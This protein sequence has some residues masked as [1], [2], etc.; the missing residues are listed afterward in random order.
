MY[1][2]ISNLIRKTTRKYADLPAFS[3]KVGFRTR[4]YTYRQIDDYIWRF[5]A[6]LHRHGIKKGHRIVILSLN[7]PEYAVTILGSLV[8]G[9]T[10]VPIDYRTNR[11]TIAKF[12][13][14][15]DPDAVFTIG[16]FKEL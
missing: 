2:S 16:V 6:F 8:S 5:P 7:R 4:T 3:L 14:T 1:S 13:H 10:I 12:I 9:I 15:T 11:E